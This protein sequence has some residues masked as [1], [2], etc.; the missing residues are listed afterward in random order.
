MFGKHDQRRW[1][2]SIRMLYN[3]YS[4]KAKPVKLCPNIAAPSAKAKYS[5]ETDSEPVLWRKGEKNPKKGSKKIL[6]PYAYK[7]SE[8]TSVC[9]GVPF[10]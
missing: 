8:H 6:K 3:S 7:R 1:K 9:D 4:S 2:S 5:W 10:A